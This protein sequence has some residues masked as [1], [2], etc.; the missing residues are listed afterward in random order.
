[1]TFTASDR[2]NGGDSVTGIDR[3]LEGVSAFYFN[4]FGDLV[5]VQQRSNARQDVFAV[6]GGSSQ[7]VAVASLPSS[8]TS[9][10]NVLRQLICVGSIVSHQ[11][12]S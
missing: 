8:A 1:M 7:D 2:L 9:R 6:G 12:L 10:S 5:N 4:D 11:H 3:T